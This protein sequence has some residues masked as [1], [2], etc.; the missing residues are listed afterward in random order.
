MGKIDDAIEGFF[1]KIG[2]FVGTHPVKVLAGSIIF[3]LA[4]CGGVSMLKSE[5]RPEKQWVARGALALDHDAYVKETWPGNSRFN[6]FSATCADV[7]IDECNILD[8]KYIQRFHELNEKIMNI[9]IDGNK[10]VEDTDKAHKRSLSDPKNKRPWTKYAGDWTF[11]GK[12]KDINGSVEF[13]GRKCFAFGPF[14]GKSSIL[15]VFRSD[16][17]VIQNLDTAGV[18]QAVNA[19]EDQE[20]MCP[21]SLAASDSPCVNN[22]CQKYKTS[23]ERCQCRQVATTYCQKVCPTMTVMYNGE[24]MTRPK[25]GTTCMDMGCIQLGGLAG[26]NGVPSCSGMLA[27][28]PNATG[29]ATGAA[30]E[31]AF[32]FVPAKMK[33]MVGGLVGD[34]GVKFSRGKYLSGYYTLNK[35]EL[36]CP[37]EGLQDPVADE[38]ERRALCVLGIDADPE[39]EPKLDCPED[40]LLK[41]NGLFQRS[42]SDEFGAAIRGDIAKISA[43]YFV[44]VIYCAIMLGKRDVVH[45]AIGMSITAVVIVGLTIG[46]TMGLMGYFGVPNSNL[47]N[48]LYFLILGLGVDDAFVL[49]SEFFRHSTESPDLPIEERIAKT[50]RTGGISVLI[51]SATDALAFLVGATTVLPALSWFCTWAGTAIILCYLFQLFVFLP[52][53]A[54]NARRV[55]ASRQ[56]IFCC[57]Q[58]EP[59]AIDQP[60][61]CCF[62]CKPNICVDH[63]LRKGMKRWGEKITTLPGQIGTI[64]FFLCL[65]AGGIAGSCMIYKDFKLEWFIPD[66]SYVNQYFKVNSENFAAG[67][68]ISINMRDNLDAFDAQDNLHDLFGYLSTSDLVNQDIDISCWHCA[69]TEWAETNHASSLKK[70]EKGKHVFADKT[71]FYSALHEWYRGMPGS[72]YRGSLL[73]KD[74]ECNVDSNQEGVPAGCSATEGVKASRM[75]AE[76][77]LAATD[78][79]QDRYNTMTTLRADIDKRYKDAFPYSFDFLYWEEVGIIDKELVQNLMICGAVI[80]VLV[81]ALVPAPRISIWVVICICLSIVDV[82]GFMHFWGVTISGVSTIYILICVGLAVDYA[83]HI[84]HMF[85]DSAGSPRERAIN[86]LERIGPCT[87]NAVVST[88]LAVVVVGF[89]SSYVFRVF[90]KVLFLVV[91]IAGAH[92]LWLLPA[93]LSLVGGSKDPE[94]AAA[95]CSSEEPKVISEA[96]Q[97]LPE[98]EGA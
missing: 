17:M 22:N 86:A 16:D 53:L 81:F 92:G 87:L 2:R 36:F 72:R 79:G 88:F 96:Q 83:A 8:P 30:P 55:A 25:P 1:E 42:F 12:A 62:C 15:D 44:I 13:E 91:V 21:L 33:T 40:L 32:E 60:Q 93:V 75:N 28:D 97:P 45:S 90:F 57:I 54:I 37:R 61:G 24:E 94:P 59:R 7:S 29:A 80:A 10:I 50:A 51:T 4:S 78:K 34:S 41:F 98:V 73:W 48:N 89:S 58:K 43:S 9:T 74:K 47:N 71:S 26:S 76:L 46:C 70:N 39:A 31:S 63:M 56:D 5:T 35:D 18:R 3:T 6:L 85:K 23:M 84:A 38:W 49:T 11:S 69:F 20:T 19:W 65:A 14:C 67:T 68:K 52:G 27:T 82:L 95:E 77:T 66:D 64:F